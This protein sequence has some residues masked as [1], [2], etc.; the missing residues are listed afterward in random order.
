MKINYKFATE[1]IYIAIRTQK[2]KEMKRLTSRLLVILT[3][4]VL[5]AQ[6]SWADD[7]STFAS[8]DWNWQSVGADGAQ[9]GKATFTDLFGGAQV[10]SI[11][12]YAE[13]NL[14]T[15]LV[16]NEGTGKAT[17]T[18]GAATANTATVA[19]NGSYFDN[20]ASSATYLSTTV[21]MWINNTMTTTMKEAKR[22][23]GIVGF[24][25]Q[26]AI[27][28]EQYDADNLTALQS[29]Y[30][31]FIA[32]GPLLVLGGTN[33][34]I[35]S[36]DTSFDG[37]NPRS[38]IGVAAD[39][40][41]YMVVV[42]G[43]K[44]NAAGVT[45]P[46][47]QE[48]ANWLGLT[49]AL[50]LDG[51]GSSA[52]W[53]MGHGVLNTP[54][55][56]SERI[57]PSVIIAKDK[58]SS[59]I[60]APAL[61]DGYYEIS[62]AGELFWFAQQVNLGY[63]TLNAKLTAD[64][65]LANA[66]WTP[67]G[68]GTISGETYTATTP[69]AGNFDGQ[70]YTISGLN[71]THPQLAG[72]IGFYTGTGFIKN[73]T[74]E[75]TSTCTNTTSNQCLAGGVVAFANKV[76][77]IEDIWS[78]VSVTANAGSQRAAGIIARANAAVT[79]N[80]CRF[81]GTA[82]ATAF[83][84]GGIIAYPAGTAVKVTNCLF[85]GTIAKTTS[86]YAGGIL[87][88]NNKSLTMTNCLAFGEGI[89][90]TGSAN[91]GA[92]VSRNTSTITSSGNYYTGTKAIGS[93]TLDS[94]TLATEET[95]ADG[96]VLA[97]LAGME[98]DE[99]NLY[100]ATYAAS[101][102][103]QDFAA[104]QTFPIPTANGFE[105]T[106][107]E[108][109]C[110][111]CG[112]AIHTHK[113]TNGFC[114]STCEE[115]YEP[116][117]TGSD[118]YYEIDNGGKLFWFA[119]Q[120]NA[121]NANYNARL[122]SDIDL[123]NKEWTPI[124]LGTILKEAYTAT[125][126]FSG[127]FDGQG[128]TISGLN[129][130]QVQLAGLIGYYNGTGTI[131]DFTIEGTSS[132]TNTVTTDQCLAAGVVAYAKGACKIEGVWSKVNVTANV[133]NQRA[134]G[135]VGRI[136]SAITIN[137]CRYSGTASAT[138]FVAGGIVAFPP[139]S[140]TKI[141]N[142]MFDGTIAKTTSYAGGIVGYN[143]NSGIIVSG[144]LAL[145]D[146]IDFTGGTAGAIISKTPSIS[147]S[148]NYYTGTKGV[149]SGTLSNA[150]IAATAEQL[151]NGTVLA[152]LA[153]MSKGTNGYY[154]AESATS[155]WSQ[156]FSAG[157]ALPLPK[158]GFTCTHIRAS[159]T[160]PC[161]FCGDGDNTGGGDIILNAGDKFQVN[162]I[163]YIVNTD[164][165][166][167][168]VTYPGA[169]AP[170]AAG[171]NSYTGEVTI[172]ASVEYGGKTYNITAIGES[173]F[174]FATITSI[175]IAEGITS[176]GQYGI[177]NCESLSTIEF[178]NSC[179]EFGR[180]CVE[181][182][183]LRSVTFGE[184][185]INIGDNFGR[186][187]TGITDITFKSTTPPTVKSYFFNYS[188]TATVHVPNESLAAYKAA[189]PEGTYPN[190][191]F[192]GLDDDPSDINA[193]TKFEY[194]GIY[195]T[196]N[197]DLNSVTV[198][199]PGESAPTSGNNSYTGAI[200]IPAQVEY[201]GKSFDV[202]KI[203]D[204][205]FQYSTITSINLPEGITHI[206]QKSIY[207]TQITSITVP[208]SVV[209]T[210]YE[211]FGYNKKLAT[212]TM[213][214]NI[215]T[216]K[217]GDK[218]FY[219]PSGQKKEVYMYCKAV[220]E[221]QT[222]T[223]SFTDATIHVYPMMVTAFK[224]AKGWSDLEIIGDLLIDYTYED[225][226]AAIT[227]YSSSVPSESEIGTN[228]GCYTAS[229]AQAIT[230]AI[231]N[232]RA[233]GA[234]A[235]L[236]QIN[237][238]IN[239]ILIAYDNIEVIPLNEGIYYIT[240]GY[241]PTTALYG[242]ASSAETQGLK[243]T[244]TNTDNDSF[245][246]RLTKSGAN[247]TMQCMGNEM[248]VGTTAGGTGTGKN[249]SLT[250]DPTYQQVITWVNGGQ[251][252]I[253]PTYDN[254]TAGPT[255]RSYGNVITTYDYASTDS[256]APRTYWTFHPADANKFEQSFNLENPRV[257]AY[258]A[259]VTYATADA[260]KISTYNV[261]PPARRDQPVPAT[262]FWTPNAESTSQ[263]LTI[264]QSEDFANPS[265]ISISNDAASY[266]IYNLIP[267]IKYYYKVEDNNGTALVNSSFTTTGQVRMLKADNVANIRDIGGWPTASGKT[268]QYG[269]IYRGAAFNPATM[270]DE[271]KQALIAVGIK[272]ELDLRSENS[273]I[274]S[275]VL[276]SS[277]EYK[278]IPLGQ[279]STYYA[280]LT[281]Y[282]DQYK[283]DI[284]YVFSC[285][286][287][288]KPVYFHCAIGADR[289]GTLAFLLEGVLGVCE[290][291]LYKDYE[292]TT[293][294]GQYRTKSYMDSEVI[295][296]INSMSGSTLEEK[297]YTYFTEN[298]GIPAASIDAFRKKMLGIEDATF[299]MEGTT[300]TGKG[301]ITAQ[302]FA[303]AVATNPTAL[304]I[305]LTEATLAEDVTGENLQALGNAI[306]YVPASSGI[307]GKNIVN[308]GTCASLVLSDKMDFAPATTFTATSVTYERT[309]P[310]NDGWNSAVL[311]FD[312][313][314]GEG[315]TVL[316]NA[317]LG[318][319][320]VTFTEATN[321]TTID[322]NTPFIY[323][324]ATTSVTFSASNVEIDATPENSGA[325]L[326]TYS[327]IPASE[328]T[329]KLILNGDGTAFATASDTA[330]IPAFRAYMV[331]TTS[332]KNFT[333]V[334]D[335]D[336]TAVTDASTTL[337]AKVDVYTVD[338]RLVRSQVESGNALLGLSKGTYVV[339]NKTIKK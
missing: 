326:G 10:I 226:Q 296:Y 139:V 336:P 160:D 249:I 101:S 73:F 154:P 241:K 194:N 52:L 329:G 144:C 171:T 281:T 127:N 142:C 190:F 208:N 57:V 132:I 37:V 252:T 328:A 315:M 220:P 275:S 88:Y 218:L 16:Y 321:G 302:A 2:I 121:G 159:E 167:A 116:A 283:K 189:F 3:A 225:L 337:N 112:N 235:T 151:A 242:D 152:G 134:A 77:T 255:L 25:S 215:A 111:F 334:I 48:I 22:S 51:G 138:A 332:S 39:R 287:N 191:T 147:A 166:T 323:K 294:S 324:S 311:P 185:N 180:T 327:L 292:L 24:T 91:T 285:V 145:G 202:T 320:T 153:N 110:I 238:A 262:I 105:C 266:E 298:L 306:I 237:D 53:A 143:N 178:P 56:G 82:S 288:D 97:V 122:T 222:Y 261:A 155:E 184:G 98:K 200:T 13:G 38:M 174:R 204:F 243:I 61:V 136:G 330:T 223:F 33:Q 123:E 227:Q 169:S 161:S 102:W 36:V 133:A 335:N 130:E 289:T 135:I 70:G 253:K 80:R 17:T 308:D 29:K 44:T 291:D 300:L 182:D 257:R 95:L 31:S 47:L 109:T 274:T 106:H 196:V 72:F 83:V 183:A 197:A 34:T 297:F 170:G 117:T 49:D 19:I 231:T 229:S 114:L 214:E 1:L 12:K 30:E 271:E 129:V 322:A 124:G 67:I 251:F 20:T 42:D 62:T 126:P 239:S 115:Y 259:E 94:Y 314:V 295:N 270:T 312:I 4:L 55:D 50:N 148:N 6:P 299:T 103:T 221:L 15:S 277:V 319:G 165:T 282:K 213:G 224:S 66:E 230:T 273:E 162:G 128:H 23:N 120:V 210:A 246:F 310:E 74:I 11:I 76:C 43:R 41:I 7:Q 193:G 305:D 84:A 18:S 333:I 92:L 318:E 301:T 78:K 254:G 276:G 272:A 32:S 209:S 245:Y 96:T 157:D 75:G 146:G 63:S 206:G 192:V 137:R 118:G 198:T 9:C 317:T 240:N 69:F 156:D 186:M 27:G 104:A 309:L 93:G 58:S 307:T 339:G 212:V 5:W 247:W 265:V 219:T 264:S 331:N 244:N 89:D 268:I 313:T 172:P 46:Q 54:S 168:T 205:A 176:I 236:Q 267:G 195:Y 64:I 217:W 85:D 164:I 256:N 150:P 8:A 211:S 293:F 199:Y 284:E 263:T 181:S 250:A 280:G 177:R 119:Q 35:P 286:E 81:S 100:P 248:Y 125:T 279:T 14:T 99:N 278:R 60:T 234:D 201:Q 260:Q 269:R 59:S 71:V 108:G 90:F 87:G 163:Y 203:G 149:A 68:L 45:I 40:T 338:G 232:A 26:G 303:E 21:P 28:F 233:L 316:N 173:A 107:T 216:N 187:A 188:R 325:L 207:D 86:G 304:N 175:D 158:V 141:T 228:P 290:S 131:K 113:Y 65:D 140:G 179:V 258:M 79:I